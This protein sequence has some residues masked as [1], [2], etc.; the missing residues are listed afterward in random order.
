MSVVAKFLSEFRIIGTAA[1][2]AAI[3]GKWKCTASGGGGGGEEEE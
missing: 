2:L 3:R 1:T